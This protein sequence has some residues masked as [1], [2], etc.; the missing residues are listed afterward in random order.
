MKKYIIERNIP[1]IGGFDLETLKGASAK[2]LQALSQI[3][4]EI[5]WVESY[6]AGDKTFCV[7]LADNKGLI[8][9]YSE[10]S[11]F[12]VNSITEVETMICPMTAG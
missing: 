5:Q 9:K 7:Y 12:P 10:L 11:G 6:V 3:G 4:S 8:E 2:S 1:G